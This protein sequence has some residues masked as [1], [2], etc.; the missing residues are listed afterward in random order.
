[1]ATTVGGVGS[2]I[3]LTRSPTAR[4]KSKTHRPASSVSQERLCQSSEVGQFS[5][6]GVV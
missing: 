6:S 1:M 5:L 4:R 3:G 2:R